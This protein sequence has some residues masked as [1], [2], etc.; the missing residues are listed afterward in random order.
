MESLHHDPLTKQPYDLTVHV[1]HIIPC[2]GETCAITTIHHA[3]STTNKCPF[4]AEALPDAGWLINKLVCRVLS[5]QTQLR[6]PDHDSK[7]LSRLKNPCSAHLDQNSSM[8]CIDDNMLLCSKCVSETSCHV[9][10]QI[11]DLS[12]CP[13]LLTT[14]LAKVKPKEELEC[15]RVG[16][17]EKTKE[18]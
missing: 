4:C 16:Q 1:P 14:E 2:C 6:A 9:G 7:S 18:R 17:D 12:Q 13:E 10:H 11:E 3:K 8:I 15:M 5:E